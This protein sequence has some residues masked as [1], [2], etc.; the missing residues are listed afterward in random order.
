MF[1]TSHLSTVEALPTLVV[2]VLRFWCLLG[3]FLG[4]GF[5]LCLVLWFFCLLPLP[6]CRVSILLMMNL[7]T[8]P[9]WRPYSCKKIPPNC[10]FHRS[11][12]L[13][14]VGFW[15]SSGWCS[16]LAAGAPPARF[17]LTHIWGGLASFCSLCPSTFA[18][19]LTALVSFARSFVCGVVRARFTLFR[20]FSLCLRSL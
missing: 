1:H 11:A 6:I 13:L 9:T 10:C 15:F 8:P 2:G 14:P 16:V 18:S 5:W 17:P 12:D 4:F 7:G 20:F 19:A 3:C